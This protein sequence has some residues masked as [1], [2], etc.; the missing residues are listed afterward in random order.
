MIN[1]KRYK[2]NAINGDL[3]CAK[4]IATDFD[5]E[6]VQIKEKF[7]AAN[8]PPRFLNS[9][10]NDSLNKDNHEN[11]DFIIPPGFFDVKPPVILIEIPYCDKNEVASKQ[12]IKKFIKFTNDK[13]DIRIKWLTRK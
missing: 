2:R 1:D 9:V 4:R 12:F 7:L 3:H 5:N 8:F 11:T 6:I 13:Y 10:C